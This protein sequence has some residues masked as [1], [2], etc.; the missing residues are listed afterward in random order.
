MKSNPIYGI[1]VSHNNSTIDWTKVPND[2]QPNSFAFIKATEG[3]D[4]VDPMCQTN[5]A[6]VSSHTTM[7]FGYYHFASL[8]NTA[9][10]AGDARKEADWF[11]QTMSTMPAAS[12]IPVLD[13]ETNASKLTQAQVQTWIST[14]MEEMKV[15]GYPTVF[16][17]SSPSFLD[18]NLPAN[19]PFG[20]LP[21]WIAH[22]TTAAQPRL[23]NGWSDYVVWQYTGSG[24]VSGVST[25]CDQNRSDTS[26]FS[27][28]YDQRSFHKPQLGRSANL[29]PKP[30]PAKSD[31]PQS[32]AST[33]PAGTSFPAAPSATDNSINDGA[34]VTHAATEAAMNKFVKKGKRGWFFG[35]AFGKY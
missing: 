9:D 34:D 32:P 33:T 1:D 17:Y 26:L 24:K 20:N 23:P 14:F 27:P 25:A 7:R 19:H 30:T 11:V 22:Y 5:A 21:L 28:E 31:E 29:P 18:E 12:L 2:A 15:K 6:A 10:V 8:N 4:Y 16:I 3:V 35:I 13:I